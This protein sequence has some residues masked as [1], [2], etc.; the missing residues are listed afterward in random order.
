MLRSSL[1]QG[2]EIERYIE[3]EKAS[4]E[5]GKREREDV[6]AAKDE[7]IDLAPRGMRKI[8]SRA[9]DEKDVASDVSDK[10]SD[11]EQQS[12]SEDDSEY[13]V[14][15]GERRMPSKPSSSR[16]S[17]P[18]ASISTRA[19]T[20]K[21]EALASAISVKARLPSCVIGAVEMMTFFPLHDQWPP[22]V[23]KWLEER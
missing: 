3:A 18:M 15:A 9:E 1:P 4:I 20:L 10:P 11:L 7:K 16:P 8:S 5:R 22:P 21:N 19:S 12:Q 2:D 23:P 17:R 6:E 14:N 13:E